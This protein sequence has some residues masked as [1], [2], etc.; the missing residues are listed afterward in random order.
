MSKELVFYVGGYAAPGSAGLLKCRMAGDRLSLL[1]SNDELCNPSW[2]L[3]HP[4]LPVLYAVEETAE[5]RL[6]ALTTAGGLRKAVSL[7]TGG[8]DPCHICLSPEGRHLLVSNY[9]GGSLAVFRLDE[10]GLPAE[11]TQLLRHVPA[12]V[13]GRISSRQEGPHIHFSMFRGRQAYVNDLGLD[14][15]AVYDW[16]AESGRLGPRAEILPFPAG[17]GPRHSLLSPDGQRLYALCELTAQLRVFRREAGW[18]PLQTVSPLAGCDLD[19]SRFAWSMAA[20]VKWAGP[21]ALCFSIRGHNSLVRCPVLP[22]S[23]L[24]KALLFPCA[25]KT[26]RDFL[27]WG[28]DVLVA[29]QDSD[30]VDVLR[31]EGAELRPVCQMPALRPTCLAAAPGD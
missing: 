9:T 7:P 25:G 6:T 18:Q 24:G 21:D 29:L 26:P 19:F 13:P 15:I 12:P 23:R 5:G 16:D 11:R 28:S 27:P 20:A 30:R 3:P 8:A 31:W 1:E 22:D 2:V 17:T 10:K 14:Q 4:T